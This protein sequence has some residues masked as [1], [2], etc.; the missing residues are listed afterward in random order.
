MRCALE[1]V[2]TATIKAEEEAARKAI[3]K[4]RE[5]MKKRER[6]LKYCEKLGEELE[7]KAEKGQMPTATMKFDYYHC[8]IASTCKD[9]A[10]HRLSYRSYDGDVN[11]ELMAEWFA[12]Y[13]FIIEIKK[14]EFWRYGWGVCNGYEMVISPAMECVK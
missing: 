14:F 9:Y 3:E 11:F 1:L 13:C 7:R 8:P 10:D 2:M 4:Q 5:E 12:Q 6:T